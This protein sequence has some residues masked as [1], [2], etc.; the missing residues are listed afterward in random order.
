MPW[1]CALMQL[2]GRPDAVTGLVDGHVI[3]WKGGL[4]GWV[5]KGQEGGRSYRRHVAALF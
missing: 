4:L 5:L 1:Y 3:V 2:L